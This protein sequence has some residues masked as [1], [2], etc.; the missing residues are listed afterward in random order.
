MASWRPPGALILRDGLNRLSIFR[1]LG[2]KRIYAIIRVFERMDE[3]VEA[4]RWGSIED[5]WHRGQR[6]P[7]QL[8]Q[9][10]RRWTTGMELS[11]AVKTLMERGFS[12]HYAYHLMSVVRDE[13]LYSRVAS[14]E[15]SIHKAIE[16]AS[17]KGLEEGGI[18]TVTMEEEKPGEG[19]IS[20]KEALPELHKITQI[21]S[22]E[23]SAKK[24]RKTEISKKGGGRGR[25]RREGVPGLT[26]RLRDELERAFKALGIEDESER[27]LLMSE[28]A[29]VLGPYPVDT[30]SKAVRRWRESG[31]STSFQQALQ[32][33]MRGEAVEEV[34][35]EGPPRPS[36]SCLRPR[37]G[38]GRRG[39]GNAP[40]TSRSI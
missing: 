3:A 16:L 6:D 29:E 11:K 7:R 4:A 1:E 5:N 19:V 21:Q 24:P 39:S 18:V 27:E 17:K 9:L 14:G 35:V 37:E 15:L 23:I 8:I 22:E 12:R 32:E 20:G 10:V 38:P 36:R 2:Y 13:D 28:A 31:G 26:A 30:Q 25:P 40:N 34:G 33:V